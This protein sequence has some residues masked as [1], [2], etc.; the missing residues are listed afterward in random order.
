MRVRG[1]TAEETLGERR[2]PTVVRNDVVHREGD[3]VV[4]RSAGGC[5]HP[6]RWCV[7]DL[8]FES[9]DLTGQSAG[10]GRRSTREGIRPL[11][12]AS[13]GWVVALIRGPG[14]GY[15]W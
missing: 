3:A 9:S 14:E 11:P 5:R 8:A 2:E 13:F 7:A 1:G 6:K 15:R 10:A 4:K 12:A